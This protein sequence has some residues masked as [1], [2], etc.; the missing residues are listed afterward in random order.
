MLIK[1]NFICG[2]IDNYQEKIW[3]L[4]LSAVLTVSGIMCNWL[5]LL[6][7]SNQ[8]TGQN[9]GTVGKIYMQCFA[10]KRKFGN[11]MVA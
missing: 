2:S 6:V 1:Y 5:N 7:L 9:I 8:L 4:V 3:W 11:K 10:F